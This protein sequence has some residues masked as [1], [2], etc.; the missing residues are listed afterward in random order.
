VWA[1]IVKSI[2]LAKI[3]VG[4]FKVLCSTL[5]HLPPL[6]DSTVSDDVGIEPRTVATL[7]LAVRAQ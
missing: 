6:E 7:A 2:I 3:V 1:E 5:L 4:I